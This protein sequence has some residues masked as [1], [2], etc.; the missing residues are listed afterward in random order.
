MEI[1]LLE[2][3]NK[4]GKAG[5]IVNVKD[6]FARNFLIPQKKAII[7]NKKNKSDLETRMSEISRNNEIKIKEAHD[8]KNRIDGK[9]IKIEM[10]SNEE[11]N[12]YGAV[13]QRLIVENI[14]ASMSVKLSAD[15]IILTPIKTLGVHEVKLRLYDEVNAAINLELVNKS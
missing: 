11:G 12:L 9:T 1:I 4:L 15:C 6:G 13:T 8:L 7:A 2:S 10:E 3:L 14:Q 5:D